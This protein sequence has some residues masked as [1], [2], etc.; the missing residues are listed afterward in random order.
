MFFIGQELTKIGVRSR[1]FPI[2]S[3][4]KLLLNLSNIRIRQ[5]LHDFQ[6]AINRQHVLLPNRAL[7]GNRYLSKVM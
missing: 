5:L 3:V 7:K 4:R 2:K 6:A 1:F